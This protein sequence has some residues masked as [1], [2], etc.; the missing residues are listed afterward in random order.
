MLQVNTGTI[1]DA[2]IVGAACSTKKE[3][4]TRDSKMHQIRKC[5]Q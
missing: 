4:K 5:P 1:V 3:N 2:T